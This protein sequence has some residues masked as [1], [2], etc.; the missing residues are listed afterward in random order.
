MFTQTLRNQVEKHGL[1]IKDIQFYNSKDIVLQRNSSTDS[2]RIEDGRISF[3][4]GKVVEII[5]IK[6]ETPGVC[7]NLTGST[8]D[9][10][11]ED[12][13]NKKLIFK[14]NS[15]QYELSAI[16]FDGP[17]G[18]VLYDSAFF[19]FEANKKTPIYLKVQK[20]D[21]SK[22]DQKTRTASGRQVS[23]ESF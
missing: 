4:K 17:Y 2:T 16:A 11:F 6:K 22:Y 14:R 7:V 12:D 3:E 21:V 20:E 19:Y 10:S 15:E 1:D 13:D 5:T 8:L 23:N 18:R 9:I